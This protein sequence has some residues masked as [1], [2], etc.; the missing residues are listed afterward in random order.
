[1]PQ[2]DRVSG[3]FGAEGGPLIHFMRLTR[4]NLVQRR[5]LIVKASV[6]SRN[7]I[8][9][10]IRSENGK[11]PIIGCRLP[12]KPIILG[13]IDRGSVHTWHSIQFVPIS[14]MFI[15]LAFVRSFSWPPIRTKTRKK[16]R[17][18]AQVT[19]VTAKLM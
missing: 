7:F 14:G 15:P 19:I 1:M 12:P 3:K 13:L 5:S 10:K 11:L 6:R 8:P 17:D 2:K 18:T 4:V 16:R 9:L